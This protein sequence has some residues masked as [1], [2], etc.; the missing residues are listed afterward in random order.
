MPSGDELHPMV[1]H[2]DSVIISPSEIEDAAR[3]QAVPEVR[4]PVKRSKWRKLARAFLVLLLVGIVFVAAILLRGIPFPS[5]TGQFQVG[6]TSYHL[7]DV[8][9][10]EY[11]SAE[12]DDVRE[13]MIGVHYPAG[14]TA[15]ARRA[16]YADTVLANGVARAFNQP[17]S[18]LRLFRSHSLEKPPCDARNGGFPVV[19]F[20]PGLGM[21]PLLYT[22]TLEDLASHGFVVVSVSHPYSVAITAFPGGRVVQSNVAGMKMEGPEVY[23]GK[24]EAHADEALPLPSD[25]WVEDL[26]FVLDELTRLNQD[27]PLLAGHMDMSKAGVFGHSYGG[28]AS[29][30]VTQVDERFRAAINMDGAEFSDTMGAGIP[31]PMMWIN[32]ELQEI[33][34]EALANAG[35]TRAWAEERKRIH[36]ERLSELFQNTPGATDIQIRGAAHLTLVSD[37]ALVGSTWPWSLLVMN[38]E[39]GTIP[40]RRSVQLVDTCVVRFFQNHLQGQSTPDLKNLPH[41]FPEIVLKTHQQ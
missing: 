17:S 3:S 19:I 38:A 13:L 27:D 40:G 9:R 34:D 35:K 16:P 36:A 25:V 8:S 15:K 2:R 21:P 23:P 26:R 18:V 33:D 31:R 6:R 37:L 7:T 5:P 41:E 14:K 12:T 4:G 24:T 1:W 32:A 30:R 20:S 11:F 29:A 39:L 22:A 10:Q 28:A